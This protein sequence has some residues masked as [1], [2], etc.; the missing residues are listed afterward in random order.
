MNRVKKAVEI[1]K[2]EIAAYNAASNPIDLCVSAGNGKIG[3]IKNISVAPI[4]SCTGA[5]GSCAQH[6]YDIK[7]VLQYPEVAKARARNYVLLVSHPM[8]FYIQARKAIASQKKGLFRWNVGGEIANLCY[9]QIMVKLA[10]DFPET[11]F[12][13]FTKNIFSSMRIVSATEDEKQFRGISSLSFRSGL[14]WRM[15]I[16]F[17][18]PFLARIRT[19]S[20]QVGSP[21]PV[22]VSTAQAA[23]AVVGL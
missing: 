10:A 9:L 6:C 19:G 14:V 16:R 18:F 1:L 15:I 13:V 11:K 17:V 5:C 7:A 20:P 4:L 22:I 12:L 21:A 23:D 2:K 3:R 8:E